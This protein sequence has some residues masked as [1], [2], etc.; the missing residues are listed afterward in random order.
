MADRSFWAQLLTSGNGTTFLTGSIQVARECKLIRFPSGTASRTVEATSVQG[1]LMMEE[2]PAVSGQVAPAAAGCAGLRAWK[3]S[4]QGVAARRSDGRVGAVLAEQR[5]SAIRDV[6]QRITKYVATS[7][8]L[9]RDWANATELDGGL[10]E[11]VRDLKQQHGGDVGVHASISVAQALLVA[12]RAIR[13]PRTFVIGRQLRLTVNSS[14]SS[15]CGHVSGPSVAS[16]GRRVPSSGA[17][18]AGGADASSRRWSRAASTNGQSASGMMSRSA[19]SWSG[20]K[21]GRTRYAV[22]D[23]RW[24]RRDDPGGRRTSGG[25]R[26][27]PLCR[28]RSHSSAAIAA[29]GALPTPAEPVAAPPE[30]PSTR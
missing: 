1:R 29:A 17:V 5:D 30:T 23:E 16:G 19:E 25:P 9:D 18:S 2:R 21:A 20:S 27:V 13:Q 22:P 11:F 24:R 14:S 15:V 10:V 4:A 8:P 26:A 7:T 6:H 3:I 28:T 12:Y